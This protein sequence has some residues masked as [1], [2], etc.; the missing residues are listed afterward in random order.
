[1]KKT[2]GKLFEGGSFSWKDEVIRLRCTI[3]TAKVKL[4]KAYACAV[5]SA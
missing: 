5:A 1:M 4:G 3:V 2:E